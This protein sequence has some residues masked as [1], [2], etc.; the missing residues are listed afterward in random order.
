MLAS[1]NRKIALDNFW[2]GFTNNVERSRELVRIYYNRVLYA[3]Y[4]FSS[5]KEGWQNRQRNDIYYIRSSG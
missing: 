4:F 2:L 5:Y 3:N 1:D